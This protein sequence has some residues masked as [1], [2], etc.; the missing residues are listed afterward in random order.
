M[1]Q[2]CQKQLEQLIEEYTQAG[3]TPSL[4]LHSCCGPC[5]SYV[6]E[7]LCE[8]FAATLYYYNPNIAPPEEYAK[9]LATQKQLLDALP[10]K[11][12]VTLIEGEYEPTVFAAAVSGAPAE[13]EGGAR[14]AA[15]FRLRLQKTAAL[16]QQLGSDYFTTTLSVSPYKN[17]DTL[18]QICAELAEE[19]GVSWLPSDF[20]KCGGYQRSIALSRKYGLYRQDF[21]GC[22]YSKCARAQ[23]SGSPS[24]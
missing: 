16:A 14:C 3:K 23:Q 6:L 2:N 11:N 1:K 9:R 22:P 21:C 8:H 4:L 24:R 17:A 10:V 7:Y 18:A 15:C 5:S 13:P 19:Y 20:K 12:P